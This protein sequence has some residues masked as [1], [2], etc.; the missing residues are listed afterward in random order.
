MN[1]KEIKVILMIYTGWKESSVKG[2]LV[3]LRTSFII[4]QV[5]CIYNHIII[6]DNKVF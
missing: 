4:F 6:Y 5:I 2:Y 1:W 3:K